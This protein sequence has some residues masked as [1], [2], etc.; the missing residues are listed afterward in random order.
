MICPVPRCV[1]HPIQVFPSVLS[2]LE[3]TERDRAL[4][5]GQWVVSLSYVEKK[6][7][8]LRCPGKNCFQTERE[9]RPK[10]EAGRGRGGGGG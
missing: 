6:D 3:R 5:S 4:P 10:K 2:G 1:V 8:F 7:R 9:K